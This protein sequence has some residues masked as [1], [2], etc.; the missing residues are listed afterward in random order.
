M[1]AG[2]AA[3]G[4]RQN[5]AAR[6]NSRSCPPRRCRTQAS[7]STGWPPR[8]AHSTRRPTPDRD[9]ALARAACPEPARALVTSAAPRRCRPPVASPSSRT[10][11]RDMHRTQAPV[12]R[13]RR[14]RSADSTG[15][16]R[17]RD[18][19]RRRVTAVR[20]TGLRTVAARAVCPSEATAAC[21]GRSPAA[22]PSSRSSPAHTCRKRP[23]GR[24]CHR[25]IADSTGCPTP[26]D[27]C[28]LWAAAARL[29]AHS[30]APA[31]SATNRG[32]IL[33]R[34]L[35]P[36]RGLPRAPARLAHGRAIHRAVGTSWK[37]CPRPARNETMRSASQA[38]WRGARARRL[39][40]IA[41][42]GCPHDTQ[43]AI[44]RTS[45]HQKTEPFRRKSD[46]RRDL[47]RSA[48]F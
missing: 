47:T 13:L 35:H 16:P 40:R 34:R 6:G 17:R 41:P 5:S 39:E 3:V 48:V 29:A 33:E 4:K 46:F 1:A 14:P 27:R 7:A 10:S 37:V 12:R 43:P 19:S 15:R 45:E 21:I 20:P 26:P 24:A 36:D 18:R 22:P 31:S 23:G 2:P 8:I 42:Q 9:R 32:K 25:R 11:W 28:H 30:A 44:C 38:K